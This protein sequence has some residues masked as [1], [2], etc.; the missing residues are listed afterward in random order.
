LPT[1]AI[2]LRVCRE[3]SEGGG[4]DQNGDYKDISFQMS[5]HAT[6]L[7][8]SLM[9]SRSIAPFT[10]A[11]HKVFCQPKLAILVNVGGWA[12]ARV[13]ARQPMSA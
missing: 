12:Q 10:E 6:D 11:E 8:L 9:P 2:L 13:A 1:R 7:L 5:S 4:D 3:E